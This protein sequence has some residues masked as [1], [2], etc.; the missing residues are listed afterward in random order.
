MLDIAILLRLDCLFLLLLPL[1]LV[2]TMF[3]VFVCQRIATVGQ[4]DS[5]SGSG[6]IKH[7]R[8]ML[9]VIILICYYNFYTGQER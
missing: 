4:V 8:V 6:E 7:N 2:A 1:Y 3:G 5:Q 9:P